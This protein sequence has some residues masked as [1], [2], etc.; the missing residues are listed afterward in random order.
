MLAYREIFVTLLFILLIFLTA[1][2]WGNP[3]LAR[4][5]TLSDFG[6][7]GVIEVKSVNRREELQSTSAIVLDNRDIR[8]RV[9]HTPVYMLLQAPGVKISEF[10]EQG[11]VSTIQ[12]RG[13]SG[14]HAGD[15][16]FYL[17]GIPLNDGGHSDNYADTTILIPL[18]IE[19]VEII[20]GPVSALYGKGNGAGTAAFQGIKKGDFTRLSLRYGTYNTINAT[21]IIAKADGDLWH[22][23]A[24]DAYH[25][26]SWR[27]DSKWN[28]INLSG[29]W[30]YDPSDD[31]EVSLNVR[32]AFSKWAAVRHAAS[33]LS[34]E[35]AV[36]DGSGEGNK[37]GGRR[38]RLDA[39]LWANYFVSPQSQLSFYAFA[40]SLENNMA[41]LEWT[42]HLGPNHPYSYGDISGE[43]QT[44]KRTAFGIGASYNH[45]G[46]IFGNHDFSVT[47]GADYLWEKQKREIFNLRWGSGAAHHEQTWDATHTL[48]TVSLY[49]EVNYQ[50]VPTLKLRIGG[51]YDNMWGDFE[52]GSRDP[53]YPERYKSNHKSIFSPKAGILFTP[54]DFLEIY[55]SY[56]RGFNLPAL[57]G[58]VFYNDPSLKPTIRDQVELGFRAA[59]RDFIEFGSVVYLA[60]TSDDIQNNTVTQRLEN[61][62]KTRRQGVE[63][64]VKLFPLEFLTISADYTYQDVR[65][66]T[67]AAS[68]HLN[69]RRY[70]STPRHIFNFEVRYE[71]PLGPGGR[72]SLNWNADLTLRDDPRP[73]VIHNYYPGHNLCN[74]DLQL[75]YGINEK[76]RV[77]FDVTNVMNYRPQNGVPDAEGYYT[78]S[79][80]S[81][82]SAYLTMEFTF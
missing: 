13:F 16:G 1:S 8:D 46:T 62:G 45:R 9:Y 20:K 68:P 28:R 51:R 60:E 19:S 39:R 49:G 11:V 82:T 21:G 78:Y 55:S 36:D 15:I 6:N 56:G 31:L 53:N 65:Y 34:P 23:Y 35:T 81:P 3:L 67:N 70:A 66:V 50:I 25:T 17:D 69:G 32:A 22:V 26:D 41:E 30:T 2:E 4:D 74:L 33:W 42:G 71:P 48:N 37:T 54:L 72:V 40:T 47:F 18:E 10:N 14:G 38:D 24:F 79:P 58:A 12:F 80:V 75:F 64:Y 29:R 52:R 63:N 77:I 7:L 43:D 73:N 61:V 5:V 76:Y 44:G 59:P 27:E 57:S